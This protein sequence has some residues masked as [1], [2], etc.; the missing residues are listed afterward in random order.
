[1]HVVVNKKG[2][3]GVGLKRMTRAGRGGLAL[4][5]KTEI[6][7]RSTAE[8]GVPVS[9]LSLRYLRP[10][11]GHARAGGCKQKGREGVGLKTTSAGRGAWR[12]Q[13]IQICHGAPLRREGPREL[14]VPE[15]PATRWGT[16]ACRWL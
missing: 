1:M 11:E 10:G 4:T 15:G 16:R 2:R 7:W 3:E 6:S 9:W 12:S 14:V 5:G 13:V 8:G